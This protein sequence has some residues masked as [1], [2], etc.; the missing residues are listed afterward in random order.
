MRFSR[1]LIFLFFLL[2]AT[3]MQA[4]VRSNFLQYGSV[5]LRG[6][7]YL[8]AISYFNQA[9]QLEPNSYFAYYLRGISKFNL[10]DIS[11]AE[12]DFSTAI[13]LLPYYAEF[14][15]NRANARS[16]LFRYED[17]FEDYA[18]A[19]DVDSTDA[20]IYFSRAKTSMN[21][22]KY[23]EAIKDCD[24]AISLKY[25]HESIYILRGSAKAGGKYY[26]EAIEDMN[27]V[28]DYNPD[29]LMGYIQ[30]G[31]VWMELNKLD[32]AIMDFDRVLET[33]SNNSYAYFSRALAKMRK[34]E[35][36]S[37]LSD[38]DRVL[39]NSPRNSYALFNKAIIK[40]NLGDK[41][42]AIEE[43]D[44]VIKINPK[45]I[46]SY[47]YRGKIKSDLKNYDGALADFDKTIEIHPNFSNGYHERAI[48]RNRMGL[49]DEAKKDTEKAAEHGNLT[50]L[51]TDNMTPEKI[52][53]LNSLVHLSGD[54][55]EIKDVNTRVQ[56]QYF[57]IDML[58]IFQESIKNSNPSDE[59]Y[60][61]AF[62]KDIYEQSLVTLSN[63]Q[64]HIDVSDVSADIESLSNEINNAPDNSSNYLKR[65]YR[66]ASIQNFNDA[67]RDLDSALI[68]NPANIMAYFCRANSKHQLTELIKS[69][70][71]Q[72]QAVTISKNQR[73][74]SKEDDS[75]NKAYLN[76]ALKDYNKVLD[77]D[78]DFS[79]AY[80]NRGYINGIL[81]DYKNAID[82][83]TFAIQKNKD[84]PEAYYNR[85][86][87]LIFINEN[88]V[89]CQDLS[90]A[91]ELGIQ[92]AYSV[93]KRHCHK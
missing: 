34:S 42:G 29:Y 39:K 85:G 87:L 80:Y 93:M 75:P 10:D 41:L 62:T 25:N 63:N 18:R 84:F 89:G 73:E 4:Q 59:R 27:L 92:N 67:F 35:H 78:P 31:K 38:L 48:I 52:A 20:S 58:P 13:N 56:Y 68:K 19:L 70:G 6:E 8:Q 5:E 51:D 91:G 83:F 22:K 81:G 7:R 53:Y 32:T 90:K 17:A 55:T 33:D 44:K 3:Q 50:N 2:T 28:L 21:L 36:E 37:A 12:M 9:I 14:F 76:D 64:G 88:K 61:D 47:F 77:L 74:A 23:D 71:Y 72:Q 65:A 30:R 79:F 15:H 69:I 1:T 57:E 66:F 45:N 86:L 49:F 60:Y 43:L 54:F 40:I 46:T 11:G 82:D 24:K 26:E 16:I